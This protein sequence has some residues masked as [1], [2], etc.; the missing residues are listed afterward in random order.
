MNPLGVNSSFIPGLALPDELL[1]QGPQFTDDSLMG[2]YMSGG[3]LADIFNKDVLESAKEAVALQYQFLFGNMQFNIDVLIV[4]PA[5]SPVLPVGGAT[6]GAVP[7]VGGDLGAADIEAGALAPQEAVMGS[8]LEGGLNSWFSVNMLVAF[9][10]NMLTIQREMLFSKLAE[11]GQELIA[12]EMIMDFARNVADCI[13]KAAEKQAA[14]YQMQ[15]IAG[16]LQAVGG[17]VQMG[18]A[19]GSVYCNMRANQWETR[20]DGQMTQFQTG[21]KK[22]DGFNSFCNNGGATALGSVFTGIGQAI[23]GFAQAALTLQKAE[24]D[25]WKEVQQA[26]GQLYQQI[27][28]S[29]AASQQELEEMIKNTLKKL[30]EI[31]TANRKSQ[32]ISPTAQ[33]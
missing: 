14:M 23:S 5:D 22:L 1:M 27:L 28:T 31:T 11:L 16:I 12:M 7:G 15:A 32:G 3:G 18:M 30:E 24:Y 33:A 13:I 8:S 17:F 21:N 26:L 9:T 20:T 2:Q 19:A 6:P 4:L 29:S 10:A 25:S